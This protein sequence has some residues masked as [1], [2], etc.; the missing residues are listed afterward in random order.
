MGV[1]RI[2]HQIWIHHDDIPLHKYNIKHIQS[3]K[4]N[5]PNWKYK[6][7]SMSDCDELIE[8]HFPR[9]KPQYDAGHYVVKADI[10]RI[11]VLIAH[12]G[13]YADLDTE[14][15]KTFDTLVDDVDV[16][17]K[18][19]SNSFF[20]AP[21]GAVFLEKFMEYL[22]EKRNVHQPLRFAGPLAIL[23]FEKRLKTT[24]VSETK[25]RFARKTDYDTRGRSQYIT[26]LKIGN[27]INVTIYVSLF[28][29]RFSPIRTGMVETKPFRIEQ[30]G[31]RIL[32]H[33][34]RVVFIRTKRH[35]HM[36]VPVRSSA[37]WNQTSFQ[38][39]DEL[40]VGRSRIHA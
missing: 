12:G 11:A 40:H 3:W 20:M 4:N 15:F 29:R 32:S 18:N 6:L 27:K 24:D 17:I 2:I 13:I 26:R 23:D 34:Q 28:G 21:K 25:G 19:N 1:P 31:C 14:C 33:K 35:K 30:T 37:T 36:D 16:T 22:Y 5:H 9:I 39:T 10:C 38:G 8:K 7:W